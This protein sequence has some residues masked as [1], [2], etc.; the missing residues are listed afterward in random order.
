MHTLY[1]P[2]ILIIKLIKFTIIDTDGKEWKG[3]G[4]ITRLGVWT[5]VCVADS[6]WQRIIIIIIII[7]VKTINDIHH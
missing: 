6:G 2:K 3:S 4:L 5:D 1:K 7:L